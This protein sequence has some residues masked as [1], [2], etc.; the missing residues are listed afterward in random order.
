MFKQVIAVGI[1]ALSSLGMAAV[2]PP[3]VVPS[4]VVSFKNWAVGCDNG[5][6]CQAVSLAPEGELDGAIDISIGRNAALNDTLSINLSDYSTTS[7][8]YR[9]LIDN[10]VVETGVIPKT[11]GITIIGAN[12]AKLA[13]AM[14]RGSNLRLV[15]G[16]GQ[17]LGKVSLAGISASFRYIDAAQGRAGSRGAIVAKGRKRS[18]VRQSIVPVV[19]AKRIA[20]SEQ[21]P[22]TAALVALSEGSPCAAKRVG[23]TED[24]A[25][26]LGPTQA[27]ILLNCGNGAYNY[28]YGA[29]VGNRDAAGKWTFAP[30][31]F[32]YAPNRLDETSELALLVNAQW[33]SKTQ[34]VSGYAKGRGI[35]DCGA[36]QQHVWDGGSFRLIQ[37]RVMDECR[38]SLDWITVWRAKVSLSG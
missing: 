27:L 23:T 7:E 30:A 20:P 31:A 9:I 8:R 17:D 2:L 11:A 28:S 29:Y 22:D 25:Y 12:A 36:S 1:L 14:A 5:G 19:M 35:G 38:G 32:D 3:A 37:A 6:D 15:D 10:R 24:S 21:L 4:K 13:R 18:A 33:D 34:T 16:D 26:S